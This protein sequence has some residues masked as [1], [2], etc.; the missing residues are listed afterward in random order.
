M[1]AQVPSRGFDSLP[2]DGGFSLLQRFVICLTQNWNRHLWFITAPFHQSTNYCRAFLRKK[3]QGKIHWRI[4]LSKRGIEN[5]GLRNERRGCVSV[6]LYST[7]TSNNHSSIQLNLWM[8]RW[9]PSLGSLCLSFCLRT[10]MIK[11][12]ISLLL[13]AF[14]ISSYC[15]LR[16][17]KVPNCT[18]LQILIFSEWSRLTSRKLIFNPLF[19]ACRRKTLCFS[20]P[21]C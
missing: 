13:S 6:Q 18:L 3:K 14:L 4:S 11:C 21:A 9:C 8:R 5:F 2:T 15:Y 17:S 16:W 7:F 20:S 10:E 12:Y 1:A 19:T